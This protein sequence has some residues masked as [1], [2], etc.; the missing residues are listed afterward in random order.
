[1]VDYKNAFTTEKKIF[2][3]LQGDKR[4]SKYKLR[5]HVDDQYG[6]DIEATAKGYEELAIEVESTQ[7]T[8][9]PA[10]APFPT[11]WKKFSVPT[12]KK[13]FFDRHPLS[14]FVKVNQTISDAVVIPMSYVCSFDRESYS[15]QT[16]SHFDNNEFFVNYN[17][18]HPA[19]CFCKIEDLPAVIDE[20]F[21][22]MVQF[23]KVNA[24]F[25]AQRPKFGP[26]PVAK[27]LKHA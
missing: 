6:I 22:H 13:K 4:L 20:H 21:K 19:L 12:R 18:E 23:K 2:E 26:K 15:N 3:I 14:L 24:K 25:T 7:G 11:T 9:W 16:D 8:K 27:E 1:M 17:S 10:G 5:L